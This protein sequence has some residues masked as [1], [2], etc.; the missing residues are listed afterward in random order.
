VTRTSPSPAARPVIGRLRLAAIVVAL[1]T[2]RCV[3][4]FDVNGVGNDCDETTDCY[5]ALVCVHL[6]EDDLDSP[7]VCMPEV[8]F[9]KS[10][11]TSDEDCAHLGMPVDAF[12]AEGFCSCEELVALERPACPTGH[13]PGRFACGCVSLDLGEPGDECFHPEECVSNTCKGGECSDTCDAHADCGGGLTTC[14]DD[15]KCE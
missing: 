1:L 8:Q 11:C 12:C 4:G 10:E 2:G 7:T 5:T 9:D 14:N 13:V 3:C 15:S 6:N